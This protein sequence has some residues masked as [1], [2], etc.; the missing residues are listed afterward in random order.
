MLPQYKNPHRRYYNVCIDYCKGVDL[1]LN[2]FHL[3]LQYKKSIRRLELIGNYAEAIINISTS[4]AKYILYL[5]LNYPKE[6]GVSQTIY[7]FPKKDK[8]EME[9]SQ[10]VYISLPIHLRLGGG[11]LLFLAVI[12]YILL[13]WL[14]DQ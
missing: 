13:C 6:F 2:Q 1:L 4:F 8:M 7:P 10:T 9:I 3:I 11:T 14:S 5:N 12:I